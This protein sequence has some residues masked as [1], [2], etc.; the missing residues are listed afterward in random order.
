MAKTKSATPGTSRQRG[1]VDLYRLSREGS[2]VAGTVDAQTLPRVA[3]R[4]QPGAAPIEW[5]ITG[6]HDP[7]GRPAI[8][9]ELRGAVRFECQ[10]C[11][12]DV[13]WPV[14]QSTRLLLARDERELAVLDAESE[15]EVVLARAALDPLTLVEDELTL[16]LPF[17]PRHAE[18]G[19]KLPGSDRSASQPD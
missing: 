12:S 2:A 6:T 4:L 13:D 8:V 10:R 5:R 7:S 15:D 19:C 17:V 16:S 1:S 18:G 9:L 14:E 11:L 3:D